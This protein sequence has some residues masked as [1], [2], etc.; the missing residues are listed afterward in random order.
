MNKDDGEY[1]TCCGRVK[2]LITGSKMPFNTI[3]G[4]F[5]QFRGPKQ[6]KSDAS[7]FILDLPIVLPVGK[8]LWKT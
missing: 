2:Y 7:D 3:N 6:V 8:L 4:A 1:A 5:G